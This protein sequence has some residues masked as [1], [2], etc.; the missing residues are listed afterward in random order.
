MEFK[1][2]KL[3]A[4][5][6]LCLGCAPTSLAEL[7]MAYRKAC[8]KHHPDRGGNHNVFIQ[9]KPAFE[10]LLKELNIPDE[11]NFCN[12]TGYMKMYNPHGPDLHMPCTWCASIFSNYR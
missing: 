7:Q 5:D 9:L 6:L 10:L 12:G 3:K 2:D 11:C 4:L 8:M 1:M